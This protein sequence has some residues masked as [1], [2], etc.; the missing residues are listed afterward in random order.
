MLIRDCMKG[1]NIN[2][3]IVLAGVV[4]WSVS[5]YCG[6]K[7]EDTGVRK[8][9]VDFKGNKLTK[10]ERTVA[11]DTG[12]PVK[13]GFSYSYI[14]D[15]AITGEVLVKPL[16]PGVLPSIGD[17]SAG[18]AG[19]GML[20]GPWYWSGF[21]GFSVNGK[22]LGQTV[23]KDIM[24]TR[25]TDKGVVD[26]IW[27]PAWAQ[28]VAARFVFLQNDDKTYLR[29][30]FSPSAEV[31]SI[32]MGLLAFPGH[33]GAQSRISQDRWTCTNERNIQ[34][35]NNVDSLEPA[36]EYWIFQFDSQL[37]A[38]RGSCAV[39]FLPEEVEKAEVDQRNNNSVRTL[40]T[41]KPL[42]RSVRL[43]LWRFPDS[44]KKPE[45]A[46]NYLRENAPEFLE[47]LRKFSFDDEN[48]SEAGKAATLN[49][50]TKE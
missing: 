30:T 17:P 1:K 11:V 41:F 40:L 24:I 48:V 8:K 34:H 45:D 27:E 33:L 49:K 18:T 29:M 22:G 9:T 12:S 28:Q 38:H 37:N 31:S 43:L 32:K 10:C 21:F 7:I 4:C 6:V 46:Y 19:V 50:D 47:R 35:G 44:Y 15:P 26:F 23:A 20:N 42:L 39:L 3:G 16:P 13:Y 36:K 25:K 5:G 2:L 14:Q